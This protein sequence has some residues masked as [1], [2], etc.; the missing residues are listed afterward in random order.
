MVRLTEVVQFQPIVSEFSKGDRAL[1]LPR[2]SIFCGGDNVR[3]IRAVQ[4]PR[5]GSGDRRANYFAVGLGD[6]VSSVRPTAQAHTASLAKLRDIALPSG[7]CQ[8]CVA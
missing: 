1:A 8:Q 7:C 2:A 4:S 5:I 3:I 6:V